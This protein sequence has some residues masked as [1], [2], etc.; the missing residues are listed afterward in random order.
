MKEFAKR[1]DIMEEEAIKLNSL[2]SSL[3][4]SNMISFAAG[5]PALEAYPV[6]I[7]NEISQDIF[8]RETRGYEALRY[9]STMGVNDFREAIR[10]HLLAPRGLNVDIDNIMVTAG[11]IQALGLLCNLFLNPGDVVLVETPTFVQASM[12]FKMFEAKIVPCETDDDGFVMEDVEAKIKEHDPKIIYT[13]PTFHNPTGI[14]MSVERRKALA[15]LASKYD[16]MVYEDDPYREI[17]YSGEYL[18][19]IKSFDKTG[20]VVFVDSLSK[21]F[22]PG[23]RLGYL[24]ADDRIIEKFK[25]LRFG[26]DTC[27]NTVTQIIAAEFFKRGHYPEHLQN[28]KDMYTKR[29]DAMLEAIDK[30]FPEGTKHTYPDGGFYVWAQLPESLD[31]EALAEEIAD[32]L[33]ISYGIGSAFYSEGNPEGAGKNSMRL[34]FSGLTEDIIR[35]NIEILGD[36]FK[37]KL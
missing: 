26:L 32:D 28:L 17:R 6:E 15:E 36:F 34:N 16:V 14:T 8:Q 1:I 9:G 3:T 24:V 35:E 7:I 10:D 5:A 21:T 23:A 20:N 13:V 30:H 2:S 19:T 37:S 25:D 33:R 18:P 4:K 27:T 11:A 12:I 31:A 22:S 29:R